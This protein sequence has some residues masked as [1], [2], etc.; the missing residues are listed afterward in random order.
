[1]LSGPM[2]ILKAHNLVKS[3][4]GRTVV[5]DVSF[6][7]AEGEIVGLLGRNGAGKTTSFRMSMGMIEPDG[8]RRT[9]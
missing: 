7:V 5:N 6:D 2:F 9:R 3:F 8:G 4:N 1:M